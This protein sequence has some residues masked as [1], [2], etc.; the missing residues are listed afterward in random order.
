MAITHLDCVQVCARSDAFDT[1][2]R[3]WEVLLGRRAQPCPGGA[4]IGLRN[5]ALEIVAGTPPGALRLVFA[6]DGETPAPLP[7]RGVPTEVR[8]RPGSASAT[9]CHTAATDAA[10]C[11]LDHVV[12]RSDDLDACLAGY[13]DAG[14]RLALDRTFPERG[15]RLVFFR[16]GQVTLE[17]SGTHPPPEPGAEAR[18]DA[19]WGLAWRVPSIEAARARLDAA[20]VSISEFRPGHKAGTRVFTVPEAPGGVP[21]LFLEDPSRGDRSDEAIC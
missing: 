13:R 2:T 16:F 19:L 6:E 5:S 3:A 12:V 8:V 21:T 9:P 17:L 20:G 18:R 11:A 1:Q 7:T 15:V 10:V 4:R 14:L